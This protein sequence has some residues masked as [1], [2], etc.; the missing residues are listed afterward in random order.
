VNDDGLRWLRVTLGMQLLLVVAGGAVLF[1]VLL[2]DP[3]DGGVLAAVLIVFA[4]GIFSVVAMRLAE[5]RPLAC[6][7]AEA[8]SEQ[9]RTRFFLR[10][11]LTEVAPLAGF[12]A[13]LT[14]SSPWVY[15]VGLAGSAACVAHMVPL[16]RLVERD[17]ESLNQAGCASQLAAAI[18]EYPP[19]FGGWTGY[20]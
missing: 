16:T 3:T 8:L 20:R 13:A 4:V 15:L 7:D 6:T 14:V 2:G 10:V 1:A 5:R 11:A 12:F 9:F 19:R 17:Q 18:Q